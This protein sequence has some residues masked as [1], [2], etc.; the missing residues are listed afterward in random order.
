MEMEKVVGDRK[1]QR[2]REG[3]RKWYSYLKTHEIP[4]LLQDKFTWEMTTAQLDPR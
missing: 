1:G 3:R 2:G 4:P